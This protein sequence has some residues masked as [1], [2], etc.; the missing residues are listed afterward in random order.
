MLLP[1]ALGIVAV[2]SSGQVAPAT[3]DRQT[4]DLRDATTVASAVQAV[5]GLRYGPQGFA[6]Q[7]GAL[8]GRIELEPVTAGIPF[9]ALSAKW[10]AA[11]PSGA[12]IDLE[13]ATRGADGDWSMWYPLPVDGDAVQPEGRDLFELPSGWELIYGGL[14]FRRQ[15]DGRQVRA[16]LL[17]DAAACAHPEDLRVGGVALFFVDSTLPKHNVAVPQPSPELDPLRKSVLPYFFLNPEIVDRALAEE[18]VSAAELAQ[19][20]TIAREEAATLM[21][22]KAW[23]DDL[24]DAEEGE[25][26]RREAIAASGYE[27]LL[28]TTLNR[29][30]NRVRERL[31]A[32]RSNELLQW[33][34]QVWREERARHSHSNRVHMDGNVRLTVFMTQFDA[35]TDYEIALPD[36]YVKFANL[37]WEYHPG[38]ENPPYNARLDY[39]GHTV[40]SVGVL[41]VGPWNIEDNYWNAPDHAQRPRRM[42]TDLPTGMPEAQAAYF[43][44]YNGGQDQ[45]GRTVLNP[46]ACDAAFDVASDLGLGYLENAWVDVTYLWEE[47]SGSGGPL[48][49]QVLPDD[50]QPIVADPGY[51]LFGNRVT[52]NEGADAVHVRWVTEVKNSQGQLMASWYH[53]GGWEVT[54]RILGNETRTHRGYLG[55]PGN[56]SGD[57]YTYQVFVYNDDSG[58]LQ[59]S[60]TIPFTVTG[61]GGGDP[62]PKPH[63][64][65]RDEWGAMPPTCQYSYCDVTHL[66]LHHTAGS[67]YEADSF[68]ECAAA[69]RAVQILHMNDRGWCDVG[70]QYLAC[71]NG[72]LFE[73]RGG[74]DDVV[75]AH[76]KMNCG[77]MA[78]SAIG[79]Y[80]DPYNNPPTPALLNGVEDLYAWKADQKGIDPHGT[81]YY[82]GYGQNQTNIYGHRDIVCPTCG[83]DCPG[84]LLYVE[85]PGIRDAVAARIADGLAADTWTQVWMEVEPRP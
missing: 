56:A 43:D 71:A 2:V 85:L 30:W 48:T 59:D 66:A 54:R 83:T 47:Q 51:D 32:E 38:Y 12:R 28:Q 65:S 49:V 42:W 26:A 55:V 60:D 45:Y 35:Q 13:V 1:L 62:F 69:V 15:A 84:D 4:L 44:D 37:G 75:G 27:T 21:D 70:Y 25:Q 79:Y 50:P 17:V 67:G 72:M 33:M 74:G 39:N 11:L 31:G 46:G 53:K 78:V 34:R 23:S 76:D 40:A 52:H 68:D 14:H 63:V 6:L 81:S 80:H 73:G 7:S 8:Q 19:L 77:S 41:D 29:S 82:E 64:Y 10:A 18:A 16:R 61:G 36:K 24:I 58:E 20:Q 22:L 57:N 9:N 3:Y 5:T